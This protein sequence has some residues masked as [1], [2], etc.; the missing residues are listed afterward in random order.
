MVI[1]SILVIWMVFESET[2]DQI[3]VEQQNMAKITGGN[4][5]N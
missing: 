5:M 4:A 3:D 2:G 1:L